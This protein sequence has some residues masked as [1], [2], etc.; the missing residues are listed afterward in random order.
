MC[1][2]RE[3]REI[4]YRRGGEFVAAEVRTNPTFAVAGSQVLFSADYAR[5]GRE[6]AP[7]EYSASK[8]GNT[9]YVVRST[10]VP[11]PE[12]ELA[13]VTNWAAAPAR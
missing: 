6:D 1:W 2:A 10:P 9:L 4:L 11:K 12:Y 3:G 8:D 7:F 13:I 5:G